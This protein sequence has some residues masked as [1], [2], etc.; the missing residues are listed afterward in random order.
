MC[1]G[2]A[3]ASVSD[4]IASSNIYTRGCRVLPHLMN[5]LGLRVKDNIPN[6]RGVSSNVCSKAQ[7][8]LP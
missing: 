7:C 4:Y 2:L 3:I 1:E 8:D 6:L 5:R